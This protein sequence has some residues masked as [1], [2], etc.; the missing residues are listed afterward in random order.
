MDAPTDVSVTEEI[1]A[2]C[3]PN[4]RRCLPALTT[5]RSHAL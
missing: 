2:D 5:R 1:A 4:H 3:I